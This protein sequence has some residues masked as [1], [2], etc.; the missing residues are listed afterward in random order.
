M[1]IVPTLDRV[2]VLPDVQP[3]KSKGGIIIPDEAKEK[4]TMG[5]VIAVGPGKYDQSGQ[6]RSV[7]LRAQDRV[8]YSKYGGIDHKVGETTYKILN[9]SEV[10]AVLK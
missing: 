8:L 9:E 7:T 1:N 10:F 5:T 4:P 3:D 2:L 6:F